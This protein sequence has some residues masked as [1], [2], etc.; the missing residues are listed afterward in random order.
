MS[1]VHTLACTTPPTRTEIK[2][3][4]A[5][6]TALAE[7]YNITVATARKK[8]RQDD[9]QDRSHGPHK[10]RATLNP[11]QELLVVELR[12]TLLLPLDDLLT[13]IREFINEVV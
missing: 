7:R 1:Q 4:A 8:K 12:R 9:A 11:A 3:S 6:L 10:L 13:V 5:S 2:T